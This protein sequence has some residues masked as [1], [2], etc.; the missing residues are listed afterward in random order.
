MLLALSIWRIHPFRPART[1]VATAYRSLAAMAAGLAR[2]DAGAAAARLGRCTRSAIAPPSAAA[3]ETGRATLDRTLRGRGLGDYARAAAGG[4]GQ[5]AERVFAR[6]IA[7][8]GSAPARRPNRRRPQE[9][10]GAAPPGDG[11]VPPGPRL[12]G[13]NRGRRPR[14]GARWTGWTV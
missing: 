1:G 10:L 2:L 12:R 11:A 6:L 3:I 14:G 8:S 4:A 13:R 7:L 9:R 5:V